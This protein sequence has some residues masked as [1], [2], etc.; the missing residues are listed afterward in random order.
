MPIKGDL[1]VQFLV[2]G[3]VFLLLEILVPGFIFLSVGLG[4]LLAGGMAFFFEDILAVFPM[5]VVVQMLIFYFLT[6]YREK[7]THPGRH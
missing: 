5:I 3:F 2:V 7:T 4:F 1:W 6:K